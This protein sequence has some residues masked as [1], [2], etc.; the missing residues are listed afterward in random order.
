M[1]QIIGL[2][3]GVIATVTLSILCF[4]M[5]QIVT[6]LNP[7][8]QSSPTPPDDGQSLEKQGKL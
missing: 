6:E 5:T 3:A 7:P 1:E 8:D 2:A 4:G